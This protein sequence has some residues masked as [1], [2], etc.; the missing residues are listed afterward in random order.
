MPRAPWFRSP[1]PT[2]ATGERGSGGSTYPPP[3]PPPFLLKCVR[4]SLEASLSSS[5]HSRSHSSSVYTSPDWHRTR[6]QGHGPSRSP[7]RSAGQPAGGHTCEWPPT[8]PMSDSSSQHPNLISVPL[9][10]HPAPRGGACTGTRPGPA[11]KTSKGPAGQHPT[12]R[13]DLS[14]W[15]SHVPACRWAGRL[16]SQHHGRG[17]TWP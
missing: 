11:M 3:E 4:G 7:A 13:A 6:G 17:C 15:D 16:A 9:G 12:Q 14:S 5:V 10:I 2:L 8:V 1:P